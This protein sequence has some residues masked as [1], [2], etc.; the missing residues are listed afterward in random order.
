MMACFGL[1]AGH[2]GHRHGLGHAR[3]SRSELTELM[4]GVG[5]VPLVMGLFGISEIF[6]NLEQNDRP[7]RLQDHGRGACCRA[8]EDWVAARVGRSCAAP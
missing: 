1:I 3:A 2:G 4:D 8:V 6:C 5:L 7:R